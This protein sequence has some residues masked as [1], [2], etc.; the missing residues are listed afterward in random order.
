MFLEKAA[1]CGFFTVQGYHFVP[2]ESGKDATRD[3]STSYLAR[4]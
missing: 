2:M 1:K 4:F 3:V